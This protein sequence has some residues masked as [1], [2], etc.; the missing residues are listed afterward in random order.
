MNDLVHGEKC[1]DS[2]SLLPELTEYMQWSGLYEP[3]QKIYV[4]IRS[5][6]L[7]YIAH[8]LFIFVV[9]NLHKFSY[10]KHLAG[11]TARRVQD[12]VDGVPF[13][14]GLATL[15]RHL[16]AASTQKF[17][18]LLIQFARSHLEFATRYAHLIIPI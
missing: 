15:L 9:S 6:D 16:G 3:L 12:G 2:T 4:P 7:P 10:S 14:V 1:L 18:C 13:V 8:L 5:L 17:C 11:L